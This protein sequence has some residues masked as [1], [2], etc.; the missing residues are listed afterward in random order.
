[1]TLQEVNAIMHE[2]GSGCTFKIGSYNASGDE[3]AALDDPQARSTFDPYSDNVR[4]F[5]KALTADHPIQSIR[6]AIKPEERRLP[7]TLRLCM[8]RKNV[9]AAAP[10]DIAINNEVI[11]TIDFATT[12]A[13]L[14][15][16]QPRYMKPDES[17]Y[18]TITLSRPLGCSGVLLFD[19]VELSGSWAAGMAD[20]K[21]TDWCFCAANKFFS[22]NNVYRD[23]RYSLPGGMWN[24]PFIPNTIYGWRKDRCENGQPI[25]GKSPYIPAAHFAFDVP[26]E[27]I[28]EGGGTLSIG[29]A[30][31]N[32]LVELDVIANGINVGHITGVEKGAAYDFKLPPEV[33]V[34]GLNTL[35]ISNSGANFAED[36]AFNAY[37]AFSFDFIRFVADVPPDNKGTIIILR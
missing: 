23:K 24:T 5:P 1:M 14:V 2:V 18:V 27:V 30:T 34:S 37:N 16:L 25:Q 6:F 15:F 3:F 26:T 7:R 20:K 12:N 29:S 28:A 19:T 17:G 4:S 33:L 9:L 22:D 35:V 8:E 21:S 36:A 11:K 10:V 31:D 32:G 13:A